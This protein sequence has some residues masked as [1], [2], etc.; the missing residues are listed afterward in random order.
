MSIE[1][2][3][4]IVSFSDEGAPVY[5]SLHANSQDEMNIKIVKAFVEPPWISI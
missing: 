4:V 5:K 3:N 2:R 1:R